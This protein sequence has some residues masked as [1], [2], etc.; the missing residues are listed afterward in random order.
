ML[1]KSKALHFL[2]LLSFSQ[3]AVNVLNCTG[4]YL[5]HRGA[6]RFLTVLSVAI[7]LIISTGL[8]V[9]AA[10]G[11]RLSSNAAQQIEALMAE[12]AARTPI[13]RKINSHLLY[14]LKMH[15][16]RAVAK[17]VQAMEINVQVDAKNQIL[18]DIKADVTQAVLADVEALGG[19]LISSFPQY[20]AIRAHIPIEKVEVL[21][22]LPGVKSIRPADEAITNR[23]AQAE[24][25]I[26]SVTPQ[27]V[28]QHGL[29]PNFS[30]R[31]NRIRT[32]LINALDTP[33]IKTA[34]AVAEGSITNKIN[35][36][37]GD[38]AHRADQARATYGVDGTGVQIGVLSD[39]VDSLAN[40]QAT[41]DLPNNV[42]IL[43]GQAGS[44]DEGTAMLEIVHD[45]A[46]GAELLFATAFN[47]QA[48]FA[49]NILALR[50]AG[51]DVIVDDVGYFAEPVFQD[52]II[53]QAV[54][55]VTAD[56]ALYFSSAGN[57]GNLN[58]GE[59]G[60]WEGDFVDGGP[61]YIEP[62]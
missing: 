31:A 7:T 44:G 15:R 62:N 28:T 58:D 4:L 6:R 40:R 50:D 32:Q 5:R 17:G 42:T 49:S 29:R 34:D 9:V 18:V 53:A 35:T 13:Q 19:E 8:G 56:G 36:S 37:E 10:Q 1:K 38:K 27:P 39:G 51:A 59:S 41:G 16:G 23:V 26:S 46:P 57:S 3:I 61:F 2:P 55:S 45:L 43:P 14:A 48:S 21:A 30:K 22:G 52:G 60:V 33:D 24:V 54:N 25:S 11:P 47:G 12:K 20:G